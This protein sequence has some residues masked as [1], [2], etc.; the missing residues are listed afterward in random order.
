MENMT[1]IKYIYVCI[2]EFVF[3]FQLLFVYWSMV[4]VY[5][6]KDYHVVYHWPRYAL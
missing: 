2:Q 6:A 1:G 3:F 4:K 5:N